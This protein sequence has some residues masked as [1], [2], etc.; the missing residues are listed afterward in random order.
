MRH[1]VRVYEDHLGVRV[2]H[3]GRSAVTWRVSAYTVVVRDDKLL[4]VK[5]VWADRY[6]LPGGGVDLQ[7]QETLAEAARRECSEETGYD[8][9]PMD[10]P[11]FL[12]EGFF[13]LR[14]PDGFC[15]SLL[16]ALKGTVSDRPDPLWQP[17][18]NEIR[19]VHWI[20]LASLSN[21]EIHAPHKDALRLLHLF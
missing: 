20:P 6:E 16:F 5:P 2:P 18:A 10:E 21:A 3:D 7:S 12:G 19:S 4:L 11:R 1:P 8:F 17:D 13:L 15:H 9:T 14:E